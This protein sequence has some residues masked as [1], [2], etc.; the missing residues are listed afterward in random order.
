MKKIFSIL[1]ILSFMLLYGGCQNNSK[2][3]IIHHQIQLISQL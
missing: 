2:E 3:K 1:I